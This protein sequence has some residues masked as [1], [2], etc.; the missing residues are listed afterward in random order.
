MTFHHKI[1]YTFRNFALILST[2]LF[3]IFLVIIDI[4][5]PI[6]RLNEIAKENELNQTS[7]SCHFKP[8]FRAVIKNE[9]NKVIEVIIITLNKRVEYLLVNFMVPSY[10]SKKVTYDTFFFRNA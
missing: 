10:Y 1:E 3:N 2:T 9:V 8:I 6:E 4:A 5:R 7:K